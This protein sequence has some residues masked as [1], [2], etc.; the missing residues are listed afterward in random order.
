MKTRSLALLGVAVLLLGAAALPLSVGAGSGHQEGGSGD[1]GGGSDNHLMRW[2]LIHL[3]SNAGAIHV[4]AGGTASAL[5][6]NDSKITLTGTGTF[7]SNPGH[8]QDVTGGGTWTTF[9]PATAGGGQ[10]AT[11]TYEVTGFVS[12]ELAPGGLPSNFINDITGSIATARAGLGV[13]QIAYSDGSEGVLVIS[14]DLP[15]TPSTL[16]IFE[17]ITAS[18]GFIDYWNRV[19]PTGS[20]S[21]PNENRTQFQALSGGGDGDQD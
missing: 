1:Q 7:R 14:C 8:S 13:L 9:A 5:A 6:A 15:T 11:G 17:G 4:S 21:G 18:K 3:S 2:D 12:Y 20:P 19:A 10:T 16:P